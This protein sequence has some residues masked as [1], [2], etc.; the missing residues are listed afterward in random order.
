MVALLFLGLAF[1]VGYKLWPVLHPTIVETATGDIHCDLRHG[2]CTLAFAD[3]ATVT[4]SIT[5][6]PVPV[7]K[8][9]KL[10]V[11]MHGVDPWSVAVDFQ[12]VDMNMGYNRPELKREAE[13]RYRG[14]TVLPVC[15]RERMD[16]QVQVMLRT[17][18]GIRAAPYRL[19]T[20]KQQ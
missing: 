9:I 8:P 19:V 15:V 12:G 14:E 4:L 18:R 16:W 3:G 5:P 13:G 7:M 6:R 17:A 20:W 1:V 2:P 11:A 10:E